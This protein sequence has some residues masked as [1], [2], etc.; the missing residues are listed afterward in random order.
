MPKAKDDSVE[1]CFIKIGFPV[2]TD[3][4]LF[5]VKKGIG[6]LLRN[7]KDVKIEYSILTVS[8]NPKPKLPQGINPALLKQLKDKSNNVGN[9]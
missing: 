7:H 6:D 8:P 9:V 4:D 1:M 2:K 5:K 3:E